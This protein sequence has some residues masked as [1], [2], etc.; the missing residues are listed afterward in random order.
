MKIL[1]LLYLSHKRCL[2]SPHGTTCT[3]KLCYTGF[4]IMQ[5]G[6]HYRSQLQTSLTAEVDYHNFKIQL[7]FQKIFFYY[8][9]LFLNLCIHIYIYIYITPWNQH[10]IA[11]PMSKFNSEASVLY[12]IF[13]GNSCKVIY[14]SMFYDFHYSLYLFIC[15]FM[16][17]FTF[18]WTF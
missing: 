4:T 16:H 18:I 10:F 1:I 14:L 6:T 9:Y 5:L 2:I 15:L 12:Q 17:L 11:F 3:C 8:N 13:K 7:F